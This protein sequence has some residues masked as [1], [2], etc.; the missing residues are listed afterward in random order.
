MDED[1]IYSSLDEIIRI[2]AVQDFTPSAAVSFIFGLKEL[3]REELV[4]DTVG[5]TYTSP[6]QEVQNHPEL[7]ELD[8]RI[9]KIALLAFNKY[10]ECREKVHEIRANELKKRSRGIW[11]RKNKKQGVGQD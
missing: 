5:A 9:D 3:I 8:S 10:M 1:N 2:R 7:F 6:L 4:D 11:E